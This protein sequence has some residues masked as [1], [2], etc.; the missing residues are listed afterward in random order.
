MTAPLSSTVIQMIK[1]KYKI[2]LVTFLITAVLSI[3]F[4]ILKIDYMLII[5]MGGLVAFLIF[6]LWDPPSKHRTSDS[7]EEFDAS[8]RTST[9]KLSKPKKTRSSKRAKRQKT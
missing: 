3:I 7:I 9:P 6:V 1:S 8:Q 2:I 4:A 5:V